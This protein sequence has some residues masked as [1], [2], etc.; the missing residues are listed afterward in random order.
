MSQRLYETYP[1]NVEGDFYVERNCC[2][3]C[4]L[5]VFS[6]PELFGEKEDD[7]CYVQ[8][9]PENEDE[10]NLMIEQVND[11]ELSCIRYCGKKKE[12]IDKIDEA[13]DVCDFHPNHKK[14][15]HYSTEIEAKEK[16]I[17]QKLLNLFKL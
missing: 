1:E 9:Q 11:A 4:G 13:Q 7:Y 5:P 6:A 16:S 14:E 2:T 15:V 8:K 3:L 17:F 12:I 10:L